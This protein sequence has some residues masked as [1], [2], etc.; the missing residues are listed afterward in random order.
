[1]QEQ[2]TAP[3]LI[4]EL[5]QLKKGK[6]YTATYNGRG[7]FYTGLRTGEQVLLEKFARWASVQSLEHRGAWL[8]LDNLNDL[9]NI[10]EYKEG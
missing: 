9:T 8:S 5:G 2:E 6:S 3:T 10:Q 1:M 4:V 7:E